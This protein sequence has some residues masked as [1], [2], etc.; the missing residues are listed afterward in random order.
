MPEQEKYW[1]PAKRYGYGWG[2]PTAWQGVVVMLAYCAAIVTGVLLL[3][4]TREPLLFVGYVAVQSALLWFV[5]WMK[6]EPAKWRWGTDP[7]DRQ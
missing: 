1:F 6:G 4:P 7:K 3:P 5:C 2:F